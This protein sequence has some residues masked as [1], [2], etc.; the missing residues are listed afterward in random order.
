MRKETILWSCAAL[1]VLGSMAQA[2]EPRPYIGVNLDP[3]SVPELLTKHLRLDPGQGLR[4]NNI[5][6]GS[7]ADKAGLERDD[8]VVT[9][10]G[11][12][13]TE[14]EQ[15]K[16]GI[17][18]AGIG[19]KVALE[20]IHLGERRTVNATLVSPPESVQWKYPPEADVTSWRPGKVWKIGPDGQN[21]GEIS[22]DK[23]P[24]VN[25]DA[26]NFFKES[27][28]VHHF[29][30]GDDYS[31]TIEGDPADKDSRLIVEAGGQ[32]YNTTVGEIG[33]LPEK[34]RDPAREAVT[35]ARTSV[36][37]SIHIGQTQTPDMFGPD[38]RQ[39]FFQRLPKPDADRSSEQ[40]DIAIGKLQ[41]QMQRLQSQMKEMEERN[42]EMVEKLLQKNET[43][44]S[45]NAESP[46]STPS[47]PKPKPTI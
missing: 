21:L 38:A 2:G 23:I 29:E 25:I 4:I 19:G 34:Y 41:E 14:L 22:F 37:A 28:T 35:S 45:Q 11:K 31:I 15:F 10:A 43:K 8:I 16:T 47:E 26:K 24:D 5:L 30:G 44:K 3:T 1:L 13:I 39:K 6:V 33:T 18:Q 42:R 12:K 20:V 27:Y 46:T 36:K 7:P 17:V 32:K 9:L 40:K